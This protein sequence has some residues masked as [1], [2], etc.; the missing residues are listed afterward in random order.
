MSWT[1]CYL[2]TRRVVQHSTLMSGGGRSGVFYDSHDPISFHMAQ[3]AR[4][5]GM[6]HLG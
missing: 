4:T 6:G 3:W 5:L 2:Q 1:P